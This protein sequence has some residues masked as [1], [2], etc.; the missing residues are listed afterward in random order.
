MRVT[1]VIQSFAPIIGGAELQLERLLPYLA[2]RGVEVTV[3]TRGHPKRPRSEAVAG[4]TVH[5][6]PLAGRSAAA[7]A[8]FVAG[9]LARFVRQRGSVDVVHT[10]GALSEGTIALGAALSGIPTVVMI[11]R[12]GYWGDLER[13]LVKPLGARRMRALARRV[14]FIALSVESREELIA[15]GVPR[16]RILVIPYGVDCSVYRPS[17]AEERAALRAELRLPAGPLAVYI[18]RLTHV[19]RVD[20]VVEAAARADGLT[21]AVVG[22]GKE[23]ERLERLA[24]ERQVDERVHF[25]GFSD[26]VPDYLRTADLFVLP[27]RAEG[28][29]NAL[30]EAM[31]CGL[32]C[33]ATP[34]SGSTELLR[35]G[36]GVLVDEGDVEAWGEALATLARDAPRR[37]AL[38][39]A[40]AAHVRDH[41]SIE[42][43]ADR[44]VDAYRSLASRRRSIGS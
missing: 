24:R 4:G 1:M 23:R 30:L 32:A 27:S 41:L 15:H 22:D 13:L 2:E 6:S 19:K 10:H 21:L 29:S 33:V 17:D 35:D 9:S 38:G 3:L 7:S 40:A 28:M 34:V 37:A 43:Q 26:R 20:T 36:R 44:L 5:R 8:V 16:A 25:V 18:G 31:A 12:S 11:L 14:S 42:Q 39:E